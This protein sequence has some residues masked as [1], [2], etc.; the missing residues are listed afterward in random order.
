MH[1][2]IV[3]LSMI[4]FP[5]VQEDVEPKPERSKFEMKQLREF[6]NFGLSVT[7]SRGS[8]R[9]LGEPT[10]TVHGRV[11][12]HEGN[13][14]VGAIVSFS[15]EIGYSFNQYDE[16]FDMTD[17][18][19]RFVVEGDYTR[20]RIVV[21]RDQ[22]RAMHEYV[23]DENDIV[24]RWPKPAK[25]SVT[26]DDALLS[27]DSFGENVLWLTTTH[28]AVGMSTLNQSIDIETEGP[29]VIEN[30]L[31]GEYSVRMKRRLVLK[32]EPAEARGFSIEVARFTVKPG[33]HAHVHAG[34]RGNRSISGKYV[35]P[36]PKPVSYTHL[37]AHETL[38]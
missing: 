9:K 30:L 26:I 1:A 16:N 11:V 17:A 38:R 22:A 19:G 3:L 32:G 2:L 18:Q 15:T 10:R 36:V 5:P 8:L 6:I 23:D 29:T 31:P 35:A 14:I 7:Q 34:F 4:A 37:R 24:I 28:Y 20:E 33:Q 21:W 12:D 13:P 25:C 27:D